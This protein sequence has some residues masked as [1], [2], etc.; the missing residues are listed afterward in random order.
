[1]NDLFGN[2]TGPLLRLSYVE[3]DGH[4]ISRD[5]APDFSAANIDEFEA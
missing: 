3:E 1:M 4:I 2:S 5:I